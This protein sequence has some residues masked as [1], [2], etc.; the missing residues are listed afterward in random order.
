[1]L[2]VAAYLRKNVIGFITADPEYKRTTPAKG[3]EEKKS[4]GRGRWIINHEKLFKLELVS[5]FVADK[6]MSN[7]LKINDIGKVLS[8]NEKRIMVRFVQKKHFILKASL[9]I[10]KSQSRMKFNKTK[11]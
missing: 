10:N 9:K 2:A 7:S 11:L 5:G 6:V 3:R 8:N 4:I 1:M